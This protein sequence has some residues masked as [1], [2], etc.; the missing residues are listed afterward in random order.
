MDSISSHGI[1]IIVRQ[2]DYMCSAAFY[3]TGK[4][5]IILIGTR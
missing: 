1:E 3:R 5:G 4:A 2:V